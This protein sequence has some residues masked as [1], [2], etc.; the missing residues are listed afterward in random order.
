MEGKGCEK[1]WRSFGLF[2][3]EHRKLREGLIAAYSPSQGKLWS[4]AVAR[5]CK[6]MAWACIE[7][8]SSW[9][10]GKGS[11]PE[12]SGHGRKLP[13]FKEHLDTALRHWV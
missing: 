7:G 8:E 1:W 5:R 2:S 12:S 6:E 3:P 13:E 10:L 11:S 4:L 9:G